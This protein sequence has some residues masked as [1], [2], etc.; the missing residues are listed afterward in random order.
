MPPNN[1]PGPVAKASSV[2]WP[3]FISA[4]P[5]CGDAAGG[6]GGTDFGRQRIVA[7]GV[8][9]HQFDIAHGLLE[10]QVDIDGGAQLD[11]HLG[12]EVGRRP[13]AN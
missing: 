7:A 5:A 3:D 10:R 4:R 11:V 12:F 8:E 1:P 13:A 6:L 2:P 9:E